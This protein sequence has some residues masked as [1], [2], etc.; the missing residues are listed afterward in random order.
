M[1]ETLRD[2]RTDGELLLTLVNRLPTVQEWLDA[3]VHLA[4]HVDCAERRVAELE[5]YVRAQIELRE[6]CENTCNRQHCDG[7]SNEA[8]RSVLMMLINDVERKVT[9]GERDE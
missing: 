2:L 4:L 8:R 3:L 9:G 5:A 6:L 1:A 7:C